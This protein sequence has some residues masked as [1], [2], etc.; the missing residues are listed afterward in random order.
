MRPH[1][2]DKR[3]KT[4]RRAIALVVLV[5]S[6][7]IGC[8]G[9]TDESQRIVLP[10]TPVLSASS[11]WAVINSTH[12]RLRDQPSTEAILVTTLWRGFVVEVLAKQNR[13]SVVEEESNYWYQV[14]F[15]GVQ[16]WVFG[17]YLGFYESRDAAAIA[18]ESL[19]R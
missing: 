9:K 14:N 8:L 7:C 2:E 17:A 10:E 5:A 16:G 1:V 13:L 15:D 4:C 18:G 3:P 6:L 12:L 19:R 11:S